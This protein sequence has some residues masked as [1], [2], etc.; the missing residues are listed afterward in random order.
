MPVFVDVKEKADWLNHKSDIPSFI[1]EFE[2]YEV[3]KNVNSPKN[4]NQSQIAK[5]INNSY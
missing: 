4:N 1:P 3:S 5:K 2:T